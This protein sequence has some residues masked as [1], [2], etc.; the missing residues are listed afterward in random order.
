MRRD[1]SWDRREGRA[2]FVK[3][4]LIQITAR[5]WGAIGIKQTVEATIEK[6]K[7]KFQQKAG[8]MTDNPTDR[9]EG[10]IQQAEAET[11]VSDNRDRSEPS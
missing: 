2:S 3:V 1:L 8:E 11:K 7:G 10:R 9:A 6:I 5:Q 4:R